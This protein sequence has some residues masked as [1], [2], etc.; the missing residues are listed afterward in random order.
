MNT[1]TN[2]FHSTEVK[3][4]LSE[5]SLLEIERVLATADQRSPEYKAARRTQRRLEK[6]LCGVEGCTCGDTFGRR[7]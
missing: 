2:S 7:G 5:A 6:A 4:R 3:T 1:L